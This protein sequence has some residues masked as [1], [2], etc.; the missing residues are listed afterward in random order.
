M[1]YDRRSGNSYRKAVYVDGYGGS[2]KRYAKRQ[3]NKKVRRYKGPIP[4]GSSYKKIYNS[5]NISDY[6]SRKWAFRDPE[7]WSHD[8][9]WKFGDKN[10]FSK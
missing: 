2:H 6:I 9:H 4:D 8:K 3:A 7:W 1:K 10:Y 5:W